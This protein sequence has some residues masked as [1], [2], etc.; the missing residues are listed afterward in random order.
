MFGKN[1]W[2]DLIFLL[3][4]FGLLWFIFTQI[5]FGDKENKKK[6]LTEQDQGKF[7]KLI[8]DQITSSS[9]II[10]NKVVDSMLQV[11]D[12]RLKENDED[13]LATYTYYVIENSEVN[14]FAT[15]GNN[16]FLFT[17]LIHFAENTEELAAVIAHEIGHIR[18]EH[19]RNKLI[20]E[21][22]LVVVMAIIS[23]GDGVLLADVAKVLI[24]S[25]FDRKQERAADE[26]AF[27]KL[28]KANIDPKN[29]AYLFRK[30]VREKGSMDE[31]FTIIS[32]HPHSNDRIAKALEYKLP[33]D[34][35][36]KPIDFDL[37]KVKEA[38]N[39]K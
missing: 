33:D 3:A 4:F 18:K 23:G 9:K 39:E 7:E 22:G 26:F 5:K 19:V 13:S 38:L 28:Q 16:V 37:N 2:R 21:F 30:L 27:E 35:I 6:D 32:S 12:V 25:G 11:I 8:I 31:S 24:G 20:K 36:A 1:T 15:L 34:F 10:T 29:M 17:G 14:A